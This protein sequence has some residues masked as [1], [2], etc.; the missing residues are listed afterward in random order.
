MRTQ[1][2][3]W[4]NGAD[5]QDRRVG[6]RETCP[7]WREWQQA[8]EKER[9]EI[10]KRKQMDMDATTFLV[11]HNKRWRKDSLRRSQEKRRQ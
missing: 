6:C 5:C 8:H 7:A 11:E 10:A 2:P 3:C 9:A 4:N 1:P